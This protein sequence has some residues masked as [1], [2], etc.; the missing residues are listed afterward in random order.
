MKRWF[1]AGAIGLIVVAV[2][3]TFGHFGGGPKDAARVELEATMD[4]YRFDIFGMHPSASDIT[5]SLSLTMSIFL[6]FVGVLDLIAVGSLADQPRTVRRLAWVNVV[7]TGALA[8]L[9][10]CYHIPPPSV[11]LAVVCV[12]FLASAA[13]PAQRRF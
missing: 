4:A 12:L 3:H 11:T 9:F 2:L 8:I 6:L 10:A 5:E 7:G 13:R 1:R